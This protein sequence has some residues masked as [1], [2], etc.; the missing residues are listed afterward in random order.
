MSKPHAAPSDNAAASSSIAADSRGAT[1][2]SEAHDQ[3]SISALPHFLP[4]ARPPSE[5]IYT[6]SHTSEDVLH[7]SSSADSPAAWLSL[8]RPTAEQ[9]ASSDLARRGFGIETYD[10]LGALSQRGQHAA[11]TQSDSMSTETA[12]NFLQNLIPSPEED[13]AYHSAEDYNDKIVDLTLDQ[14]CY[15]KTK[16]REYYLQKGQECVNIGRHWYLMRQL[17]DEVC[18]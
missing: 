18:K 4:Y 1:V 12:Y 3:F 6:Q 5:A 10:D 15:L 17:R 13:P 9:N 11:P 2:P 16:T 7:S 14:R 8:G